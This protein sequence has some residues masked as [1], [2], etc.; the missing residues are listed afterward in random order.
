[1]PPPPHLSDT[2]GGKCMLPL[3]HSLLDAQRRNVPQ[4]HIAS[5]ESERSFIQ[6]LVGVRERLAAQAEAAAAKKPAKRPAKKA[7]MKAG[8]KKANGA[9]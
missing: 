5:Y 3:F 4:C 1:M 2:V 9:R 8:V 7:V 6:F